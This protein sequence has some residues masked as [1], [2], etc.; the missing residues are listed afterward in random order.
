MSEKEQIINASGSKE[1][2]AY[3]VKLGQESRQ[4]DRAVLRPSINETQLALI[5][6]GLEL[7]DLT[8]YERQV[9]ARKSGQIQL[10]TIPSFI[11]LVNEQKTAASR[12]FAKISERV[13][14]PSTISCTFNFH[15]AGAGAAG[16]QDYQAVL[17]L[18]PSV[19]FGTWTTVS[20][21]LHEQEPFAEF[22][23]DN[24][25]DIIDPSGADILKLVMDL[26]MTSEAR[27]V[28]KTPTNAGMVLSFE[29]KT[30][31]NLTIP[32]K[33]RLAIPLFKGAERTLVEAE[34]RVRL[35]GGKILCGVRLLG[36]DQAIKD[37]LDAVVAKVSTDTG[38]EVFQ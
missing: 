17:Q 15:E 1:L 3:A 23:K 6:Q 32:D 22:L 30:K 21:E 20:G 7:K 8:A 31:A 16:W 5:P 2:A 34:F 4:L 37:A 13:G 35:A 28:G 26:E 14:E 38:I 25:L 10:S 36:V 29:D 33:I 27:A 12:M 9:P 24:R 18:T 19:K 11:S